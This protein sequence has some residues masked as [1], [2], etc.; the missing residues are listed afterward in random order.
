LIRTDYDIVVVGAGI[1]GLASAELL[2]RSGRK[3]LLL[4][5]NRY[6]CAESSGSH[7]EW[8][9]FGSLYAIFPQ[10]HFMR[11]LVGGIDDLMAYWKGFPGM[12]LKAGDLGRLEVTDAPRGWLRPEAIEYIV[13]A[14]ND[15]DFSL[16]TFEGLWNYVQKVAFLISWEALIKQFISRHERFRKFDWRTGQASETVPRRGWLDY[17]RKVIFRVEDLDAALDPHTHFR[18][19]GVDR[20]MRSD[21]IVSDLL[22]SFLNNGGELRTEANVTSVISKGFAT[23]EV[24]TEEGEVITCRQAVLASGRT[25]D[26]FTKASDVKVKK[27]LSPLLVVYP[28]VSRQNFVR[29]TPFGQKTVNHLCHHADGEAYSLIGGGYSA[30]IGDQAGIERARA[31]LMAMAERVFP[32]VKD[33]KLKTIYESYK[34]EAVGKGEARN[35]QYHVAPL[36]SNI[37]AAVPGKFSLGFSLALNVYR[38]LIGEEVPPPPNTKPRDVSRLLRPPLHRRLVLEEI[39]RTRSRPR[40][41]VAAPGR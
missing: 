27:V 32:Q 33:A 14:R 20:P 12:N 1:A 2:A 10:N 6:L 34:V 24:T 22:A 38:R 40:H 21:V 36:A 37:L 29:L 41:A 5:R 39:E 35:Y 9:H 8:F 15:P 16:T 28:A 26:E 23:A 4:E 7:H 30:E 25:M 19:V 18:V 17:S 31:E 3:V 13:T 11:T